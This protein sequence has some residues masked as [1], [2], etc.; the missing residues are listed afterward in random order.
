MLYNIYHN[1]LHQNTMGNITIFLYY[2]IEILF[3]S[4]NHYRMN[5][6]TKDYFCIHFSH[7]FNKQTNIIVPF[8]HLPKIS[9][10]KLIKEVSRICILLA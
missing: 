3:L 1:V 10:K 4:P 7:L 8:F 6:Q 5:N 2:K 9:V